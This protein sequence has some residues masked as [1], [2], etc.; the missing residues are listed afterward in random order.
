MQYK[1][2]YI[3]KILDAYNSKQYSN[4]LKVAYTFVILYSIMKNHVSE[5]IL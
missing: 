3:Q 5:K 2:F 1:K 4:T